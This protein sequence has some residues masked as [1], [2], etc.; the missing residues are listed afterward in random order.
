LAKAIDHLAS[1]HP[2]IKGLFIGNGTQE[3]IMRSM[4]NCYVRGFVKMTEL[5][6]Y[7]QLADIG[8]WPRQES[9]SMLD[10]MASGLPLIIN[11]TVKV[12]ERIEGNGKLYQEN[13]YIDLSNKILEVLSSKL[14]YAN[15][16][17][18]GVDKILNHYSWDKIARQR[19]K[20]YLSALS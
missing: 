16:S 8:V 6:R 5:P 11:H 10:A 19:E 12:T 1:K 18:F 4:K 20:E 15:M 13:D 3:E 2:E 17:K 14:D 7:Y 9:I